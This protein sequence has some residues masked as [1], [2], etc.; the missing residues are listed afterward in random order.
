MNGFSHVD[1]L[2]IALYLYNNNDDDDDN[3]DDDDSG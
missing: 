3:G 1:T 2:V